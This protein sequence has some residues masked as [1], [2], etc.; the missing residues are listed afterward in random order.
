MARKKK[1]KSSK[2][3][4]PQS[5]PKESCFCGSCDHPHAHV[6]G[7]LLAAAGLALAPFSMGMV[8]GFSWVANGVPVLAILFGLVLMVKAS[9]CYHAK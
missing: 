7:Y 1:S 2:S 6:P 3:K 5:E 9:L 8:P 4:E